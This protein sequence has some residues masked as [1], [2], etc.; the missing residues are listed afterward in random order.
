MFALSRKGR[1]GE[2]GLSGETQLAGQLALAAQQLGQA[3]FHP[4]LQIFIG[5]DPRL[6]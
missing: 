5:L 2:E 3:A 4:S 1:T 6:L